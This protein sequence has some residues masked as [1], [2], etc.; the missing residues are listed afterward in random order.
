MVEITIDG[1]TVRVPEDTT[2]LEAARLAGAT[3]PTLCHLD[4][5]EPLNSCMVCLV[6]DRETGNLVPA[7]NSPVKEYREIATGSEPVHQARKAAMELL[8][9]EHVGDCEAPCRRACP[10]F[11]HIP[12]TIRLIE[13]GRH[14]DAVTTVRQHLPLPAVLGRICPAPC[15]RACRRGRYD[16]PI[17]I[18]SIER[19][20]GDWSLESGGKLAIPR[21]PP[22]ATVAVVGSGPAGLASADLLL[23]LGYGCV[24]YDKQSEPG[25][26]LRY[27]IDEDRLPRAVLDAEIQGIERRGAV[28]RMDAPVGSDPSIGELREKFDAVILAAGI[29]APGDSSYEQSSRIAGVFRVPVPA[30]GKPTAKPMAV[31]S[32]ARGRNAVLMADLWL[33]KGVLDRPRRTFDSHAGRFGKDEIAALLAAKEALEGGGPTK[34]EG[35]IESPPA[36]IVSEAARCLRCDC[37]RGKTCRLRGLADRLGASQSRFRRRE[38]RAFERIVGGESPALSL[39]PGKCIRCGICVRIAQQA[40]ESP[41]LSFSG[42]GIDLTIRVPLNGPIG[43]AV[44]G[45]TA[46]RCADACPTGA[47]ALVK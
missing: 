36:D 13:E 42:R 35:E 27:S 37:I 6:E 7:C 15:E 5:L 47:M 23:G 3:I 33:R 28:F 30:K 44:K 9:S 46:K 16:R 14:E 43:S 22:S 12:R 21:V 34:A 45:S 40:G 11:I 4:G 17:A 20:V 18:R 32:M 41:G 8:L 29:P 10:A 2:L 24:V 39:E 19:F 31:R 1:R 26:A 25:G 38:R